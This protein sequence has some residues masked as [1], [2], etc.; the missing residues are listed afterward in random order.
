MKIKKEPAHSSIRR[1]CVRLCVCVC[2]CVMVRTGE[3]KIYAP[4][5]SAAFI[6]THFIQLQQQ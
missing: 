2:V 4:I 3:T 1:V 6:Y 5:Q